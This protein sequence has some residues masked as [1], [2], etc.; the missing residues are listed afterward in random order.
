MV[1][2]ETINPSNYQTINKDDDLPRMREAHIWKSERIAR[3]IASSGLRGHGFTSPFVDAYAAVL[4]F[5][6]HLISVAS[7]VSI[8]LSVYLTIRKF[9]CELLC[10]EHCESSNV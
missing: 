2:L 7:L 10:N 3:Q 6:F 1:K 4:V 9:L 8:G 5:I